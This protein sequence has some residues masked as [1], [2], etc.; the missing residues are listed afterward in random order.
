MKPITIDIVRHG[1]TFLNVLDR[2]QGWCD[3]DLNQH[4]FHQAAMT[5]Q[6]LA[7]RHY[8]LVV[9]SDLRRAVQTRDQIIDRLDHRPAKIS[10]D[11]QFR[12]MCFGIFEG[13]DSHETWSKIAH[14]FGYQSQPDVMKHCGMIGSM[15][16]LHQADTSKESD[17]AASISHRWAAGIFDIIQN[18]Q[19]GGRALVVTHG[20]FI[21]ALAE[22]L[23]VDTLHNYPVNA[24]VTTIT[25][26]HFGHLTMVDYNHHFAS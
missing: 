10:Q 6:A 4:G 14:Q 17:D 3:Y 16:L 19:A 9:S 13:L 11:Q 26:N 23:G 20:T 21:R 8:D 22:E 12:E 18:V 5:G 15:N 7:D 1:Q 24:G 2:M 25:T